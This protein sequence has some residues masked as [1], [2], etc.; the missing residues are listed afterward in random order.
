MDVYSKTKL[1]ATNETKQNS[2]VAK[3]IHSNVKIK[4]VFGFADVFSVPCFVQ[5]QL[6]SSEGLY[7]HFGVLVTVKIH[8]GSRFSRQ[9]HNLYMDLKSVS[10]I[11][12]VT[13]LCNGFWWAFNTTD[14]PHFKLVHWKRLISMVIPRCQF[15]KRPL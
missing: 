13:G 11:G 8:R 10:W 15:G 1:T 6:R 14:E 9:L 4:R 5:L 7:S 12:D 3:G 2:N